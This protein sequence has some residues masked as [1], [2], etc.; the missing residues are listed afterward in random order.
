MISRQEVIVP[1][2]AEKYFEATTENDVTLALSASTKQFK[3]LLKKIP[4]KKIDYAYAEG[5]WTLR[6]L[7]QHII[8]AEKVFAFRALWF[9]RHDVSPLPGFDENS[10]A[11]SSNA[12]SRKWKDMVKE[13]FVIRSSTEIFFESLDDQQLKSTGT[14]SNSLMNVAGLGFMCAGHVNH[15]VSIIKDR[16]LRK[17]KSVQYEY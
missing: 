3:K 12:S 9:S 15:H 5:K 11:A 6:E 1:E 2:F 4:K 8:D 14:A 17:K 16:Y 10:W 13:F 7:L